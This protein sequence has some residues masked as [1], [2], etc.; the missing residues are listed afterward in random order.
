MRPGVL[1]P[2]Q[3]AARPRSRRGASTSR[4][5]RAADIIGPFPDRN[6]SM[7]RPS[8][9]DRDQLLACGR[10]E[11]FGPGNARLPLPPML[12]FARITHIA[13]EGRAFGK[14][15]NRPALDTTPALWSLSFPFKRPTRL[16]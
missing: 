2:D 7:T 14:G 4:L 5:H 1:D 10:G 6:G 3:Y 13:R 8:S 9:L 16:P 11:M 15:P 12:M